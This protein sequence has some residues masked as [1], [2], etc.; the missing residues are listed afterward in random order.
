[1]ELPAET[2]QPSLFAHEV[3]ARIRSALSDLRKDYHL[4]F[5]PLGSGGIANG[6]RHT[7]GTRAV[8]EFLLRL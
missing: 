4:S 3:A 2:G 1:M 5:F 6:Y 7:T 8:A